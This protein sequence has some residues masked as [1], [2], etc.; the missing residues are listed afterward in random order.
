MAQGKVAQADAN[1]FDELVVNASASVPVLVDFW[2]EWCGPC[3]AVAPLIS[4][5]A[6]EYEG[7]IKVVKVDVD[8]NQTSA[9]KYNISAIPTLAIFKSGE[10]VDTRIGALTKAKMAE[11]VDA[12]LA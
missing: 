12:V 8:K 11:F 5:L 1:N 3:K 10:V 7:K 4:E 6:E 9:A 2:A